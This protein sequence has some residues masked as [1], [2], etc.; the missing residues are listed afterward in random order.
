VI[1]SCSLF[2][3]RFSKKIVLATLH[4][5]HKVVPESRGRQVTMETDGDMPLFYSYRLLYRIVIPPPCQSISD[6]H[7]LPSPVSNEDLMD[8]KDTKA[9]NPPVSLSVLCFFLLS[10]S[11]IVFF[12]F[13][14]TLTHSILL[15]LSL[16]VYFGRSGRLG[17]NSR[18]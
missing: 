8:V 11:H 4:K 5:V 14:L 2:V 17:F 1:V 6:I 15:T 18:L 13:L 7:L 10:V 9:S 12:F 16:T 3:V